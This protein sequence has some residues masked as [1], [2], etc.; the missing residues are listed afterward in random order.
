MASIL[1]N[2][3]YVISNGSSSSAPFIEIFLP[4]SPLPQDVNYPIQKRWYNTLT[5]EEFILIGFTSVNG[6]LQANW[7]N[8]VASLVFTGGTGT[9]GFPVSA[10]S[11]GQ[12]QLTSNA[13]TIA[14]TGT[15]NSINF[16]IVGLSPAIEKITGDDGTVVLPNAGNVNLLGNVVAN[17]THAKAVFTHSSSA[18]TENIDVQLS[19]AVAST[20][21]AKVGLS[22]F[23][24]SQFSVD[25]NGF[26]S[27]TSVT[28]INTFVNSSVLSGSAVSLVNVTAKN[29]TSIN[30]T[31]G[32]WC[33][34]ASVGLMITVPSTTNV[35]QAVCSVST[36]SNTLSG[37]SGF[38]QWNSSSGPTDASDDF[39]CTPNMIFTVAVPTTFYLVAL[40]KIV[41]GGCSAYGTIT[42]IRIG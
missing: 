40:A 22:A 15:L 32:T 30:L 34:S 2:E 23:N 10:S 37:N 18:N 5:N 11:L 19:S 17:S 42:A 8:T 35:T 27:I 31:A 24:S 7:Q 26:V 6:F 14:I 39:V 3:A 28:P 12:L 4:R 13:Q 25:A 21:A 1:P 41:S 20:N 36:T 16:D 33:I 9:T 38:S 29:V